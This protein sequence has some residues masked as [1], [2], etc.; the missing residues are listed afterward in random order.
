MQNHGSFTSKLASPGQEITYRKKN[1]IS[2]NMD[3]HHKQAANRFNPTKNTHKRGT[4]RRTAKALA[5][6]FRVKYGEAQ[7][8]IPASYCNLREKHEQIESNLAGRCATLLG[9]HAITR[10]RSPGRHTRCANTDSR[11]DREHS[12]RKRTLQPGQTQKT[13]RKIRGQTD[14]TRHG[15]YLR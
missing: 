4:S 1:S 14:A 15:T 3:I 2:A 6:L 13:L 10:Q 7:C 9:T 12:A 5:T 11:R 8:I